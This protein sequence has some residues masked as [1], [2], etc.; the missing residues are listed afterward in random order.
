M[1]IQPPE[2]GFIFWPVGTGDSTTIRAA[3]DV[4]IQLDVR[5]MEQS[6]E[7]DTAWPVIDELIESPAGG[8]R[9]TIPL[10]L[11]AHAPGQGSLPRIRGAERPGNDWG[12]VDVP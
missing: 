1:A 12:V 11:R 3:E 7:E 10:G 9:G 5:H 6:E 4:Y 8:R 2:Q